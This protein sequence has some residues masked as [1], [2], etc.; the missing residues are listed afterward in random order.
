MLHSCTALRRVA[1]LV[2][3]AAILLL[4]GAALTPGHSSKRKG[5]FGVV[6]LASRND[7]RNPLGIRISKVFGSNI[8]ASQYGTLIAEMEDQGVNSR[9]EMISDLSPL[10]P[11]AFEAPV[12]SYKRYAAHWTTLAERASEGLQAALSA[13][14]RDRA[15]SAW[16]S[17]WSDYLHLGAVYGLFG[18]LDQA[19]D[20]MP[21]GLP[22]GEHDSRFTG[23]HRIEIGLWSGASPRS[24]MPF[25]AR[26]TH[27]LRRLHEAL[28]SV[29]VSPLEYATRAHEILE[30]AQRDLL[31]GL[32]VPWSGEGVLGTAASLAA[33]REVFKT[34]EPLLQGRENTEAAVRTELLLLSRAI[35]GTPLHDG[36]LPALGE[37]DMR[38][39]ENLNGT[40]A[41]A[42][43]A[44]DELP[45]TLETEVQ[46]PL[47]KLPNPS[48]TGGS[49]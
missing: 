19:I 11:R 27:D 43:G 33:T 46:T 3:G 5:P 25:A 20:G 48:S 47:A 9:G 16:R 41:G 2:A 31:S 26:L 13:D 8:P 28:P 21:G 35:D 42:L 36:R 6:A 23:L 29:E 17:T 18:E 14:R 12:A 24:L 7:R 4:V 37:L 32:D 45:A 10:P 15:E 22:R 34:L 38:R 49:Q 30:D 39:R 44:L 40:L 1:A